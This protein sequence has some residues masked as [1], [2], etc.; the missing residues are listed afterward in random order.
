[1][2]FAIAGGDITS[3][4]SLGMRMEWGR[5]AAIFAASGGH[6]F[7]NARASGDR[8]ALF[9]VAA[10]RPVSLLGVLA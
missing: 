6:R 2:S 8:R 3:K 10:R 1:M 5:D 9:C 4:H 7:S